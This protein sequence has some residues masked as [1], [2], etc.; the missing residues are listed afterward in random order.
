MSSARANSP[1]SPSY[2]HPSDSIIVNVL[3]TA[4]SSMETSVEMTNVTAAGVAGTS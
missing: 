2:A 4:I 1:M 3:C